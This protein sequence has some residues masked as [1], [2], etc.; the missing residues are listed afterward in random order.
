M[1][2]YALGS[3]SSGQLGIGNEIDTNSLR[4]CEFQTPLTS[5]I[6][7]IVAGGNHTLLLLEDG[8]TFCSGNLVDSR[9]QH[10]WPPSTNIFIPSVVS[11]SKRKIKL[12]SA[13][14]DGSVFVDHSNH[15]ITSV[16]AS[17]GQQGSAHVPGSTSLQEF[18]NFH[19]ASGHVRAIFGAEGI[20]GE[21][22]DLD[23][24][25]D[26]T[27]FVLANG[28]VRGWGNGRRGKLGSK[29]DSVSQPE[30][31]ENAKGFVARA[32][33]GRDFTFLVYRNGDCQVL[34]TEKWGLSSHAPRSL[35]DWK[36][37]FASW[38]SIFVLHGDGSITC[39]G[40]NDHGQLAPP[41]LPAIEQFAV[42]SEHVIALT[43]DG[44]VISWGWGEHGNCGAA[45]DADGDVKGR[46]N[47]IDVGT[48]D[49]VVG[50]GA[51]CATSFVWTESAHDME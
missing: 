6:K 33:C 50:V 24:C 28:S 29:H 41:D 44:R 22:L 9:A 19:D 51:G 42:G 1:P 20:A 17:E 13:S 43:K 2:L 10:G 35:T 40:R 46:W 11:N 5:R 49:R 4:I 12:C 30:Q 21:V 14:W 47:E 31:F 8:E 15:I 45:I 26:H 18:R 48:S 7:K 3:N 38:G 32:V 23:S 36:D 39:W 27:V 16:P 37:I 25:V 34:G